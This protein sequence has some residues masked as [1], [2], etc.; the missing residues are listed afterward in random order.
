MAELN[1]TLN[2][3]GV[4]VLVLVVLSRDIIRGN[5]NMANLFQREKRAS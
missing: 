4:R 1:F 2:R 5:K 3:L